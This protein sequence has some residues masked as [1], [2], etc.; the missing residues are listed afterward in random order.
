MTPC[1]ASQ[2]MTLNN[3][4]WYENLSLLKLKSWLAL[5]YLLQPF[6]KTKGA[7]SHEKLLGLMQH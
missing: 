5:C 1:K 2:V 3:A 7:T 4:E 6:L